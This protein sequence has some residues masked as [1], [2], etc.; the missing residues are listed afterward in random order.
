M[1]VTLPPL[2]SFDDSYARELEGLYEPWQPARWP[3]LELLILNDDLA[4][5]LGI[6]ITR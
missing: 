2:F 4:A 6:D 3:A 1:S 5:E